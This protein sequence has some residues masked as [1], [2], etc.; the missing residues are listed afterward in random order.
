M[1]IPKRKKGFTK[2]IKLV[3][4]VMLHFLLIENKSRN[5]GMENFVK[6]FSERYDHV[7][8]ILYRKFA[9]LVDKPVEPT[10]K[11]STKPP[12]KEN[13]QVRSNIAP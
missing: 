3:Y 13:S 11:P 1:K 5:V 8:S 7:P 10:T 4:S 12:R 2:T 6:G 9:S